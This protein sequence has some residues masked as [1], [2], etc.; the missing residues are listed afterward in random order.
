M[1]VQLTEQLKRDLLEICTTEWSGSG[2]GSGSDSGAGIIPCSPQP[3]TN[4]P[5]GIIGNTGGIR[6]TESAKASGPIDTKEAISNVPCP[7]TSGPSAL[8]RGYGSSEGGGRQPKPKPR[9]KLESKTNS[10]N[11]H[12][13]LGAAGH[14]HA[15]ARPREVKVN[16]GHSVSSRD[17]PRGLARTPTFPKG[18]KRIFG[19]LVRRCDALQTLWRPG[20]SDNAAGKRG[21]GQTGTKSGQTGTVARPR[22]VLTESILRELRTLPGYVIPG[23]APSTNPAMVPTPGVL[24]PALARA[25]RTLTNADSVVIP[26]TPETQEPHVQEPYVQVG[27]AGGLLAAGSGGQTNRG[28]RRIR[29]QKG[30]VVYESADESTLIVEISDDEDRDA[31]AST[32]ANTNAVSIIKKKRPSNKKKPA[33][34]KKPA[35]ILPRQQ[36]QQQEQQDQQQQRQ[37]QQPLSLQSQQQQRQQLRR[38]YGGET[39]FAICMEFGGFDS[40]II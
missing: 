10:K 6:C 38:G 17:E 35:P 25:S 31:N 30:Q 9:P 13:M 16:A 34:N 1:A 12:G 15:Q 33:L 40:L 14:V 23:A 37:Q 22:P 3:A 4:I 27:P 5:S 11:G 26:E 18:E 39:E 2:S 7:A 32:I 21:S 20:T 29:A 8:R 36:Q 28:L 24:A 19:P